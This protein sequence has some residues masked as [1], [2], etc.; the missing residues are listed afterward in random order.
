MFAWAG[1]SRDAQQHIEE[2]IAFVSDI[3]AKNIRIEHPYPC[4]TF[5]V[6]GHQ[7]DKFHFIP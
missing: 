1:P 6:H 3:Y 5:Y 4:A 2:E 7:C